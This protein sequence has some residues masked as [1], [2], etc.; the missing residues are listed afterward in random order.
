MY[1]STIFQ[2]YIVPYQG[3]KQICYFIV[4]FVCLILI[5]RDFLSF[6]WEF[7]GFFLLGKKNCVLQFLSFSGPSLDPLVDGLLG[8]FCTFGQFE[9]IMLHLPS[10][11]YL[12][13]YFFRYFLRIVLW[14]NILL[15]SRMH[16]Y[17]SII[18][19]YLKPEF[20]IKNLA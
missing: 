11:L 9:I 7:S 19:H 1:Y 3:G 10:I 4:A 20:Y 12:N 16:T 13:N 8:S 2:H 17:V 18:L 15:L 5:G 14:W 6:L